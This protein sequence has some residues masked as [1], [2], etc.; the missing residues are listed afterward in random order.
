MAG[1]STRGSRRDESELDQETGEAL[2]DAA[3]RRGNEQAHA[4][5]VMADGVLGDEAIN[6]DSARFREAFMV[7]LTAFVEGLVTR[8]INLTS[9]QTQDVTQAL[10]AASAL[11]SEGESLEADDEGTDNVTHDELDD[12][13]A[14]AKS[15][16]KHQMADRDGV[17]WAM[18]PNGDVGLGF[19][20]ADQYG[21]RRDS[22]DGDALSALYAHW[23]LD[24]LGPALRM[25]S[26][27][28]SAR[29]A[30]G[31][32]AHLFMFDEAVATDTPDVLKTLDT[33]FAEPS[34]HG[35]VASGAPARAVGA[36][37]LIKD[38][39]GLTAYV[40]TVV[41]FENAE[42]EVVKQAN[43]FAFPFNE[44]GIET[45][46]AELSQALAERL[47]SA[48]SVP[49]VMLAPQPLTICPECRQLMCFGSTKQP[50]H[51]AVG[52]H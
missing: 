32:P 31:L 46:V 38:E 49:I 52:L 26:S 4:L 22:V 8:T 40:G 2:L 15:S 44:F 19:L 41:A 50:E 9:L 10:K 12:V 20:T 48:D 14:K 5:V 37:I 43:V 11:L 21:E 35:V 3:W 28:V 27:W 45:Y 13:A 36:P 1:K 24:H 29:R 42:G 39:E 23:Y 30:K 33:V 25:A 6:H 47:A 51:A 18:Q 7:V 34:N 17:L 16:G